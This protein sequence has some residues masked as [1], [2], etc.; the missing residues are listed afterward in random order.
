ML[1]Q[2]KY[3]RRESPTEGSYRIRG[4]GRSERPTRPVDDALC[5]F[6]DAVRWTR[7]QRRRK[8][9]SV[10]GFRVG[11]S[12]LSV[13]V[14]VAASCGS[15]DEASAVP[16]RTCGLVAWHRPA[17]PVG[18][19]KPGARVELRAG[20]EDFAIAHPMAEAE[21]GWR[22]LRLAPPPGEQKYVIV[23]DGELALDPTVPT[24]AFAKSRA[25]GGPP[26]E[27]REVTLVDVARCD[28]PTLR[29]DEARGSATGAAT[30]TA[31]FLA[32]S[33][34]DGEKLA[35]VR[36]TLGDG[37][38]LDATLAPDHGTITL[39]LQSGTLAAG[40]HRITLR[41][42]DVAGRETDAA[43][44][45]V[46]IEPKPWDW[47]DAVIYQV[48]VDRF[49]GRSGEA[50]AAPTPISGRAGGH[51]EGVQKA[52][53]SGE[54]EAMGVNALWLSPLY[55]NPDTT[56]PG[57][58]GRPY[59]SYHGYWPR[60]PRALEPT[61]ADEASLDAL[62]R[63]AHAHGIRV[64]F[65][66]VPNHVHDE[67]P[68]LKTH[69]DWFDQSGCVCGAQ[70]CGPTGAPASFLTCWFTPYM[71]DVDWQS[72]G[73]A[74]QFSDDVAWWIDRFDGDGVRIDAVPL[75]PRAAVRRIADVIRR[76]WDHG[77]HRTL[78]LGE[79]FTGSDG[80]DALRWFLGPYGLDSVFDFPVMWALRGALAERAASVPQDMLDVEAVIRASE[81]TFTDS[82]GIIARIAG[83]HDVPRFMSVASGH[84]GR[85]GWDPAPQPTDP[86]LYA[87][88]GVALG[89]VFSLPGA[90]T[91]YYGD[92]VGL[93]GGGDPDSRRVMP[94]EGEL[95]PPQRDLRSLVRSLG[96]AR[97]C[98]GALRRGTLRT[99][100][101]DAERL[102]LAR[103][104]GKGDPVI[105]VAT[106]S[107][108]ARLEAPLP[109]VAKGEWIDV[110]SGAARTFDPTR[111]AF[112]EP[113]NTI[114]WYVP[115]G[116][117]CL[118]P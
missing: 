55:D 19:T 68:Y 110:L 49:R 20:W 10:H 118:A 42:R 98:L 22:A 77:D 14:L 2:S 18:P 70:S 67:H 94:S 96:K 46:W 66:V 71:P 63:D 24:S 53:A 17:I 88:L 64:I 35:S 107:S 16:R 30:V 76:R 116:S 105:V 4:E 111:S 112:E 43:I 106:R 7:T 34:G 40:K 103:E 62:V 52:I 75:M 83:N 91:V 90:P 99:L 21:D 101:V 38:A 51:I 93:A 69:P 36:A 3:S 86:A 39:A 11:I 72:D 25:W 74:R 114:R 32:V 1:F 82:G 113:S 8:V 92:E 41:A 50:L 87:R 6:L 58:D 115:R 26:D 5:T 13:L 45:T 28:A 108:S 31:T 37:R 27:L 60:D 117:A 23:D 89:I 9:E 80:H 84:A 65:D 61:V 102:V 78:V 85:D 54:L 29:I 48:V 47:R 97:G 12:A 73:A 79:V 95:K 59:S 104:G 33:T 56:F 44:A 109:G 81:Q 100:A 15:E 57:A